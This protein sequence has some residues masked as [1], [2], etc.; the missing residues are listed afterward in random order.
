MYDPN[1]PNQPF[2]TGDPN[3]GSTGQG[4]RYN[5]TPNWQDPFNPPSY[6]DP[7]WAEWISAN[8][9][10]GQKVQNPNPTPPPPPPVAPTPGPGP[11]T[12]PTTI[13]PPVDTPAPA[14]APTFTPPGYT[15]P[16]ARTAPPAFQYDPFQAP[17]ADDLLNDPG[18]QFRFN[19]GR[20]ALERS[21]AARGTLNTGGTLKDILGY[22]QDL[23][24]TEYGNLFN[25]AF[26]TYGANR[27][28]AFGNYKL[29]YDIGKDVQDSNYQT[30]YVDPFQAAYRSGSDTF[31]ANQHNYDQNQ[32]YTQHNS[33]LDRQY[34][35]YRRVQDFNE[36]RLTSEDDFNRRLQLLNFF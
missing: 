9:G 7:Y 13:R 20:D 12:P 16:P 26:S 27:D 10:Y 5:T 8:P 36:R 17:S 22:G 25:R 1:D 32:Y 2:P 6:G 35:W 3:P 30:Q 33:D 31:N 11:A 24:S 28:N 15:P 18:Y 21:A 23:A 29:N 34:D 19:Q 14:P 4:T